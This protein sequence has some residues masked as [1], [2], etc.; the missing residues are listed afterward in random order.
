MNRF[1]H[2]KNTNELPITYKLSH[3]INL[4][5]DKK[6]SFLIQ[7]IFILIALVM[8]GLAIVFKFPI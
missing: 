4:S 7:V 3:K 2:I 5:D 6:I 8:V 1:K